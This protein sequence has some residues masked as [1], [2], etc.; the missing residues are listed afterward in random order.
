MPYTFL[1]STNN[2]RQSTAFSR[3]TVYGNPA[4]GL[5]S[6]FSVLEVNAS[7]WIL[8]RI[9]FQGGNMAL[10]SFPCVFV[11]TVHGLANSYV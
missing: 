10:F 3:Q 7:K 6:N 8:T 9:V 11:G 4:L 5:I 1:S 2:H